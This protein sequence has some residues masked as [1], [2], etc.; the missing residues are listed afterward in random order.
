MD[1]TIETLKNIDNYVEVQ[2]PNEIFKD[3]N[4]ADFQS[5]NHKSFAYGYYYLCTFLYR[6][7]IYGNYAEQFSQQNIIKLFTSNKAIVSYITKNNGVLDQIGYTETT[8]D[9]PV[10]YYTDDGIL[11]FKYIKDLRKHNPHVGMKHGPRLSIKKPLKS[12]V[13]TE[14]EDCTGTFY[15]Y[16]NTH[17]IEFNRF[18]KIV[19]DKSLGHV[20]LFIYGYLKMMCDKYPNGYQITCKKLG[21]VIGCTDR[22]IKKYLSR[23]E[24]VNLIKSSRKALDNKLLQKVYLTK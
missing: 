1:K 16:Q 20:G 19:E 15:S 13:R 5:F 17:T 7:A 11:E 9:Y 2:L 6:N 4:E 24:E 10:S 12:F 3:L 21:E 14:G 18:I 8:T 23:L 22:T